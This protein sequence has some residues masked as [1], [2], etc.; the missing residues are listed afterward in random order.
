MKLKVRK[1]LECRF[2]V[3]EAVESLRFRLFRFSFI[4]LAVIVF[5]C[6]AF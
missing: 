3:P 1:R 5:V 2:E 6:F 4:V